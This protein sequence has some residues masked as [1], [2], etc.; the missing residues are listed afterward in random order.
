MLKK[1]V[2]IFCLFL[3]T[4]SI[5]ALA[6][7]TENP[8][9]SAVSELRYNLYSGN[10]E[11]YK[12]DACYGFKETPYSNDAKVSE[13]VYAL[14]F[15]LFDKETDGAAYSI[16]IIHGGKNYSADFKLNPVTHT[17]TARI[18]IENFNE[19]QFIATLKKAQES[20]EI[21]FNSIV[22]EKTM[23]YRT[24][25]D[26]LSKEQTALIARYTD[27]NGNFNAEI[28]ARIV[29]KN[30]HPYWYIG[31]ASNDGLKALLIDGITGK[32]LAMREIF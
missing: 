21:T 23:N 17:V 30:E 6:C 1:T 12:L 9:Y 5:F 10:S 19:K 20:E 7:K 22:P 29:V 24:A 14:I 8:L 3:L 11:N 13:K 28:H 32:T 2:R 31:I 4:F 15:R 26:C 18:E 25:L 27:E 16:A